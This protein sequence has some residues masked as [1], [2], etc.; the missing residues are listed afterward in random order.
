MSNNTNYIDTIID[1]MPNK[2]NLIACHNFYP[3]R[4]RV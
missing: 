4:Y 1:Y 3:H 2:D